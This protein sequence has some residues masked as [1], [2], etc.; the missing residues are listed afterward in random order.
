LHKSVRGTD[1]DAALY[2]FARIVDGGCD[3]SYLLRRIARMAVEDIKLA[4]PRALQ[5]AIDA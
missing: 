2:W 5:L 3:P 4:D 1:P